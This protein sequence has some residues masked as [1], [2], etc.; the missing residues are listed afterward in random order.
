MKRKGFTLVELLVVI[1]IIALLMG[2]LMPALAKVRQIAY[3]MVCGTNLSGIGKAM[4]L[5]S[6]DNKESFPVAGGPSATW[7]TSGQIKDWQGADQATA[8]GTGT[9]GA[10]VT[11]CFFLLVK[12]DD[13]QTSQFVC[14]GDTGTK[15]FK[16]SDMGTN[17]TL[18]DITQAWDFGNSGAR[19]VTGRVG[20][21]CSYSYQYPFNWGAGANLKNFS[22]NASLNPGTP[23][24]ADRNPYLD[25]NA[26][27]FNDTAISTYEPSLDTSTNEYVDKERKRVASPHQRDGQNVMYLD[28]HTEFQRFPNAGVNYDNIYKPW[29]TTPPPTPNATE[30]QV[31]STTGSYETRFSTGPQD[32]EDAYLVNENNW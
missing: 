32:Y 6:N 9:L 17:T 15:A 4:L 11:S 2:I 22:I 28:G 8:F 21:R 20:Q 5:Y 27:Y 25:K 14:K 3:R 26:T 24:T 18:D 12:Y 29:G 31:G 13:V 10:T 16:L 1:A 19:G 23:V 7:T 30:R